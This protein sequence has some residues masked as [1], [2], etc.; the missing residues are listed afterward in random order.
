MDKSIKLYR[1]NLLFKIHF[2]SPI[3]TKSYVRTVIL[4]FIH[5]KDE[6]SK[7]WKTE[8]YNELLSKTNDSCYINKLEQNNFQLKGEY[9]L[10]L[11]WQ[12]IHI[13]HCVINMTYDIYPHEAIMKIKPKHYQW[14][15]TKTSLFTCLS[16][17]LSPP[18]LSKSSMIQK[19]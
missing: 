12:F 4:W 16:A 14:R 10:W 15:F 9:T 11:L 13:V 7:C 3:K 17:S 6:L 8:S 1:V 19:L 2:I 18:P 5:P